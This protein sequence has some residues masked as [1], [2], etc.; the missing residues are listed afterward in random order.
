MPRSDQAYWEE[1]FIRY[2]SSG[3][4]QP[5]FC[6]E[7]NLSNNQFHYR[8][9]EYNKALKAQ[10]WS[11]QFESVSVIPTD[12]RSLVVSKINVKIHLPNQIRCDVAVDLKEFASLLTQGLVC[13]VDLHKRGKCDLR[14]D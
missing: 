4:S 9:Y 2:K 8:W 11:S 12:T 14:L 5:G 1:I 7:N 13:R 10:A 3:L 6:R